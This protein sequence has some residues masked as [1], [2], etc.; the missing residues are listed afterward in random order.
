MVGHL[1]R[2][3]IKTLMSAVG[4]YLLYASTRVEGLLK[5]SKLPLPKHDF[6]GDEMAVS[7]RIGLV[8][9]TESFRGQVQRVRT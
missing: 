7:A 6:K 1:L 4:R 9:G 2:C 8:L 5:T 3:L